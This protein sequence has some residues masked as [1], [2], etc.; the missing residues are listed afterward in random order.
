MEFDIIVVILILL[1]EGVIVI[2]RLSGLE[3]I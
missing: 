3:V 1:G 2:I